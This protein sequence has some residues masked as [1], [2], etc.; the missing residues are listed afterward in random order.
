MRHKAVLGVERANEK[1]GNVMNTIRKNGVTAALGFAIL[2][3]PASAY[4]EF[5]PSAALQS[6]CRADAFKLCST[7]LSSMDSVVACRGRKSLK[8]ASGAK[9]NTTLNRNP[10]SKAT[11]SK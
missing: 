5:K 10:E 4:A 11:A 9:R 8:P 3:L 7:S 2:A 6:A 1:K